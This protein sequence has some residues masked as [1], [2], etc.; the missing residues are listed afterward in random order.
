MKFLEKFW[1]GCAHC[2]DGHGCP[3]ADA[4]DPDTGEVAL[5]VR[6]AALVGVVILVF[7]VPLALAIV[8]AYL[9][10]QAGVTV[11]AVSRTVGQVVGALVGFF[12]GVGLSQV[13]LKI[14]RPFPAADG[15]AR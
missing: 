6:G 13:V 12:G 10:G 11:L 7:L 4:A 15:G 1:F 14:W 3:V 5:P 9:L 2:R 8:G